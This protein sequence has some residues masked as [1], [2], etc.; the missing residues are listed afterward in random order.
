[1]AVIVMIKA[2]R[3]NTKAVLP[4][5]VLCSEFCFV[6]KTNPT[7]PKINENT[8]MITEKYDTFGSNGLTYDANGKLISKSTTIS[9]VNIDKWRIPNMSES[10]PNIRPGFTSSGSFSFLGTFLM[11]I[12]L[13]QHGQNANPGVI[14]VPHLL[15]VKFVDFALPVGAVEVSPSLAFTLTAFIE[16]LPL[17]TEIFF[18][19]IGLLLE[20]AF[21]SF[22]FLTL[23][24][25]GA[26][27]SLLIRPISSNVSKSASPFLEK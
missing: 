1:M 22:S 26:L 24:F 16:S 2:I 15:H 6:A 11:L 20:M 13:P 23:A 10:M 12:R 4:V 8:C 5:I 25:L 19:F 9:G 14:I 17:S 7:V 3:F 18:V 21:F 27:G